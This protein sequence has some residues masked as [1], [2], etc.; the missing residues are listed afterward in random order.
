MEL[1]RTLSFDVEFSKP[2][3]SGSGFQGVSLE[4]DRLFDIV[5]MEQFQE[6]LF[7]EWLST[8]HPTKKPQLR[9]R[10]ILA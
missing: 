3:S 1:L 7:G 2:D 8:V 10:R 6:G 9:T 5:R 4:G